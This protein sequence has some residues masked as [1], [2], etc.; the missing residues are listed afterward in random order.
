MLK[1]TTLSLAAL[2]FLAGCGDSSLNPTRWFGGPRD[3][4]PT[5]LDPKG[6]YGPSDARMAFGQIVA[7]KWEPTNEGRLLVVTAMPPTQGYWNVA[8][9]PEVAQPEGR[10]ATDADGVLRLR[11]VGN[12]PPRDSVEA[13]RPARQGDL[14]TAAISVPNGAL[15]RMSQVV[16]SG[17]QNAVTVR[18]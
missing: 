17:A 6:G 13:R 16:V 18:R 12:P 2:A 5:T 11:L 8:L 9:I 15:S 10:L 7:T 14:I 4:G 1:Q 3:T